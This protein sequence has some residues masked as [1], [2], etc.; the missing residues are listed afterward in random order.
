MLHGAFDGRVF[1]TM[2]LQKKIKLL[3]GADFLSE[4]AWANR[5]NRKSFQ[6]QFLRKRCQLQRLALSPFIVCIA[7]QFYFLLPKMVPLVADKQ[8]QFHFPLRYV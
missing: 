3:T 7:P 8:A 6:L 2:K 5:A 1:P 4:I